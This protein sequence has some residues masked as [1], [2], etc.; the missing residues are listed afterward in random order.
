MTNQNHPHQLNTQLINLTKDNDPQN[1]YAGLCT[2]EALN[3]DGTA[4]ARMTTSQ[5]L[6]VLQPHPVTNRPSP[7]FRELGDTY[8]LTA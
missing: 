8:G 3:E 2:V 1:P 4:W 6:V 7:I 5:K